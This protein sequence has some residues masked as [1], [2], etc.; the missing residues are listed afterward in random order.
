MVSKGRSDTS[1][2]RERAAKKKVLEPL[3]D[4]LHEN[5]F[6]EKIGNDKKPVESLSA[7][8]SP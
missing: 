3:S 2:V 7:L 6:E 5:P 8:G 1:S 4:P